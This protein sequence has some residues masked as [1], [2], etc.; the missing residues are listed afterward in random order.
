MPLLVEVGAE[1]DLQPDV[2]VA[3]L[4]ETLDIEQY[5][6]CGTDDTCKATHLAHQA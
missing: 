2:A 5:H 3:V 6:A 1:L 4:L